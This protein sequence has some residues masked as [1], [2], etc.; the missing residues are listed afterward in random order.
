MNRNL[1]SS[2]M[3]ECRQPTAAFHRNQRQIQRVHNLI[4]S[5]KQ[6]KEKKKR[7]SKHFNSIWSINIYNFFSCETF[8][9]FQNF[10]DNVIVGDVMHKG[11]SMVEASGDEGFRG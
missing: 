11:G 5:M 9:I 8:F 4:I 7:K 10:F 6:G 1:F 2:S 3:R